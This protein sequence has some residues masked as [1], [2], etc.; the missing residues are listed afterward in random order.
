MHY[1]RVRS[2]CKFR[3]IRWNSGGSPRGWPC[4]GHTVIGTARLYHLYFYLYFVY[5][6]C[7]F[8]INYDLHY[9]YTSTKAA[10]KMSFS[11]IK[12][13]TP[14]HG[15][16]CTL[17]YTQHDGQQPQV[18]WLLILI[19]TTVTVATWT[20][21]TK[22][23]I[24]INWS[25]FTWYLGHPLIFCVLWLF[26]DVTKVNDDLYIGPV[27]STLRTWC[28]FPLYVVIPPESGSILQQWLDKGLMTW[29]KAG[30]YKGLAAMVTSSCSSAQHTLGCSRCPC[31]V[32]SQ[33]VLVYRHILKLCHL[34]KPNKLCVAKCNH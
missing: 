6:Q 28:C 26:Y 33:G 18:L 2:V 23:L 29:S 16:T 14:I 4:L 15:F 27:R 22:T 5:M 13:S 24:V 19:T 25:M 11:I 8:I 9:L 20:S 17:L 34:F 21:I 3:D 32:P 10:K 1:L 7:V 30:E 12:S 31:S